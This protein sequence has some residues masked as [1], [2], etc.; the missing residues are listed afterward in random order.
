MNRYDDLYKMFWDRGCSRFTMERDR[1]A[2]A[3]KATHDVMVTQ[4]KLITDKMSMCSTICKTTDVDTIT[5]CV[6]ENYNK[7]I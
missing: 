3:H 1:M 5:K 2:C 4:I 7:N 6:I